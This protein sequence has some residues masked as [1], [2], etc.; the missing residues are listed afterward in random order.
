MVSAGAWAAGTAQ[1]LIH[2]MGTVGASKAWEAGAGKG[3]H[4]VLTGATIQAGV[5]DQK[6]GGLVTCLAQPHQSCL[7][8]SCLA[9]QGTWE[10]NRHNWEGHNWSKEP[11]TVPSVATSPPSSHLRGR[12]RS[13]QNQRSHLSCQAHT[14][15]LCLLTSWA[16]HRRPPPDLCWP[17]Q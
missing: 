11:N 1:T 12:G 13:W 4:T 15:K 7:T 16:Q 5:C 6:R 10:D 17:V 2:I 14:I 3:A 9:K 8:W